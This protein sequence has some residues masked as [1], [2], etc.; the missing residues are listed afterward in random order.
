MPKATIMFH[1]ITSGGGCAFPMKGCHQPLARYKRR[2]RCVPAYTVIA[3]QECI[4][5][6]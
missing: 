6:S 5:E 1:I 2:S 3:L 4:G